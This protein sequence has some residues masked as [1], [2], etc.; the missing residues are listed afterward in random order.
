MSSLPL[1]R[2]L[3]ALAGLVLL[4]LAWLLLAP[5]ALGGK[6]SF[7]ITT[8]NSMEPKLHAGDLVLVRERP[9][10]RAGQIV[11]FRSS[12]LRRD[13]LHRIVAVENGRIV[14]K[15]DNNGYRDP[16]TVP[17][18]QVYGEAVLFVPGAGRPLGWL[19][20]PLPAAVVMF[21]LVFLSLAGGRQVAR[22]RT[23][24]SPETV[25]P[26]APAGAASLPGAVPLA[27]IRTVLVAGCVS[28][29][30][31]ATLAAAAWR[32]PGTAPQPV[33]QAYEH[34]GAFTYSADVPRSVVYPTGSLET[35]DAAFTRLVR[36][37]DVV[38]DYRFEAARRHDVRGGIGIDASI[39]DGAG[40]SRTIPIDAPAPFD[41]DVA[42]ARGVLDVRR[43]EAIGQR[44]RAL[45]GSAASTFTVTLRPRVQVSGYAGDA[46]VDETF[47][48]ELR[49]VLDPVSLRPDTGTGNRAAALKP[50]QQGREVELRPAR[51]GLGPAALPVAEARAFSALGLA[52]SL[53][54]VLA[55]G[56]FLRRRTERSEAERIA[57]RFGDRIVPAATSIPADRWVTDVPDIEGLMRLADHY[58][59]VVLRTSEGSRHA[60]LVDDGITVYRYRTATG[61][62]AARK[63]GTSSLPGRA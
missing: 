33:A 59:R 27:R 46:V 38:F 63:A 56:A 52:V 10:Y 40:W 37:L 35:G 18:R 45:T 32:V 28:L 44:M 30:L 48:P 19:R 50:R 41:G 62:E 21:V 15:G 2:I 7:V 22:R 13:V 6:T 26:L 1:T 23:S 5:P 42:H 24:R 16:G 4:A 9:S 57:A 8:G 49:F 47:A 51:L 60:Y 12:T 34:T 43:L 17:L 53:A 29:A 25:R 61:A 39:S 58:D 55:A 54:V 36:R 3:S 14:T 11:L 31:F 20:Q